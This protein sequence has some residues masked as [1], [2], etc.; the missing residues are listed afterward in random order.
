MIATKCQNS[1]DN[2]DV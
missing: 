2:V 1:A